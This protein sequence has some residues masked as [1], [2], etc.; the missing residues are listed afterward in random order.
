[1]RMVSDSSTREP[2]FATS[3][4]RSTADGSWNTRQLRLADLRLKGLRVASERI[5]DPAGDHREGTLVGGTGQRAR[6]GRWSEFLNTVAVFNASVDHDVAF[7]PNVKDGRAPLGS[8]R[9]SR[10]GATTISEPPFRGLHG[11]LRNPFS[12]G[13]S[14]STRGQSESTSTAHRSRS[15]RGGRNW[16]ETSLLQ[17]SG[18]HRADQWCGSSGAWPAPALPISPERKL[19]ANARSSTGTGT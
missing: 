16:S 17:L 5:P 3:H 12:S 4:T 18:W 14:G 13:V 1:M 19:L 8:T 2:T 6:W 9:Q 11:H 7:N 10:T 15:L